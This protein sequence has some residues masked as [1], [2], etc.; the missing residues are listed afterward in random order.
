MD[1]KPGELDT[2]SQ[3]WPTR[4]YV[5]GQLHGSKVI[6]WKPRSNCKA[7]PARWHPR[8]NMFVLVQAYNNRNT[9]DNLYRVAYYSATENT[10]LNILKH[11]LNVA[12]VTENCLLYIVEDNENQSFNSQVKGLKR[13]KLSGHVLNSPE[14]YFLFECSMFSGFIE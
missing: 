7:W 2:F 9:K 11:I 1:N 10:S 13:P 12:D 3:I 8:Y 5:F 4:V 6:Q 14:C